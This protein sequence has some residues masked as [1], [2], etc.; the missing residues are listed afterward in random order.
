MARDI[1]IFRKGAVYHVTNY[2]YRGELRLSPDKFVEMFVEGC[3]AKAARKYGVRIITFVTMG[4]H[5]H[6]VVQVP[7]ANL[8]DFMEYFQ[9]ELSTRLNRYRGVDKSNFPERYVPQEIA[10]AEDFCELVARI[11][12]NPVRARLV[13]EAADWPGVS[14]LGMHR[15]GETSR[16]VRHASRRQAA[17]MREHGL[18]PKLERS[19][20]RLEL[21]LSPPPFWRDLDEAEVHRR[22]AERVAVEEARLQAE[23]DRGNERVRGRHRILDEHH[24]DR[25]EEVHWR[26]RPRCVS[27]DSE[28]TAAYNAWFERTTRIYKRAA[29]KWRLFG[30]WGEYPP[31]TFPP[32]W[33]WCLPPSAEV[34][35][36][37]PWQKRRQI[38]A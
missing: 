24:R 13:R 33:L 7:L 26:P 27:R 32:G 38:A 31:G 9:K 1:R 6:L 15:A 12:C 3:L 35:P 36:H 37:L 10:S 21:K 16:T 2:T 4:N 23:I 20:E 18:T 14:S 28:F 17:K 8:D 19:L 34:G 22:I 30:E 25:P 5:F 29:A 11:L